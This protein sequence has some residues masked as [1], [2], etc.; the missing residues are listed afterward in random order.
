VLQKVFVFE[1]EIKRDTPVKIKFKDSL[2]KI[3]QT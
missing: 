2:F 3:S 1:F